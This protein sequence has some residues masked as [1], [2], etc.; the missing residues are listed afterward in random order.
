MRYLRLF[1]DSVDPQN[2]VENLVKQDQRNVQLLLIE[3]LQSGLHIV[4]QL[5]LVHWQVVLGQP[6]AVEDRPS[7]GHLG[8][9]RED[10]GG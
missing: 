3:D 6:V 2:V 1:E 9:E 8:R 5:L 4:P 10:R 7:Q